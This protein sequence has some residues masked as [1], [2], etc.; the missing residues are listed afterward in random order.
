[1]K[2]FILNNKP[3]ILASH[4]TGKIDEFKSLFSDYN[5]KI[6]TISMLGIEDIQETGKTFEENA[7]IKVKTVPEGSIGLSDDSGLCIKSLN[8]NPGI[9]SARY[10]K[11]HGGWLQ[12]MEKLYFE[13]KKKDCFAASF[14]CVLALK[15]ENSEISIFKGEVRGKIV[16]PPRGKN[17]FGYDPFFTPSNSKKTFGEMLHMKKILLDHRFEAFKKMAKFHLTDN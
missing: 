6:K 12:A 10:A 8:N 5:V 13:A 16:W 2:K 7:I 9:F 3:I 14:H 17:G 4:N 11:K 15:A 1:M